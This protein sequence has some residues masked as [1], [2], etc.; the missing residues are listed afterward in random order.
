[1]SEDRVVFNLCQWFPKLQFIIPAYIG[2]FMNKILVS[3]DWVFKKWN[4]EMLWKSTHGRTVDCMTSYLQ[5]QLDKPTQCLL[6]DKVEDM[7]L[8]RLKWAK[9]LERNHMFLSYVSLGSCESNATPVIAASSFN[10]K[11][12]DRVRTCSS[13]WL[14]PCRFTLVG[15]KIEA[16]ILILPALGL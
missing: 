16:A 1:M 10:P 8:Q 14:M 4:Y 15:L 2:W 6:T 13:C 11:N 9:T 7:N 3:W 5:F 12:F